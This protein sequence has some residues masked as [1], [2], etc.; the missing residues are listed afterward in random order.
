MHFQPST[1]AAAAA[2]NDGENEDAASSYCVLLCVITQLPQVYQRGTPATSLY[3]WRNWG[4][5]QLRMHT[6]LKWRSRFQRPVCW[7][8]SPMTLIMYYT[9]DTLR[10]DCW[11]QRWLYHPQKLVVRICVLKLPIIY[12]SFVHLP[13]RIILRILTTSQVVL[14]LISHDI[15]PSYFLLMSPLFHRADQ[16]DRDIEVVAN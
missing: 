12:W 5:E 13:K 16:R 10:I 2:D 1:P 6:L 14:L 11:W 15:I 9:A 3:K 7:V 4:L 8:L